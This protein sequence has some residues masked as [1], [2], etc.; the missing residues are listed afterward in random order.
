MR[1]NIW[2]TAGDG[3]RQGGG[4]PEHIKVVIGVD[5]LNIGISM[6]CALGIIISSGMEER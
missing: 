3:W 4:G 2:G 5:I 1:E 6:G